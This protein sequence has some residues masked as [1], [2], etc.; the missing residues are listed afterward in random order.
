[1]TAR[2][3]SIWSE[4]VTASTCTWLTA[5]LSASGS[6]TVT[7]AS[8]LSPKELPRTGTSRTGSVPSSWCPAASVTLRP[9]TAAIERPS[10]TP[11]ASSRRVV[12]RSPALML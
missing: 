11:A 5:A 4:K 10:G 9:W 1:V 6:S 8:S 2:F 3:A 7:W 12:R